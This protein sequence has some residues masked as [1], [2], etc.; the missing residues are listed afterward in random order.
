MVRGLIRWFAGLFGSESESG[1]S[2]E[3]E[4]DEGGF[5]PS[6]L[7]ASVLFAHGMNSTEA[8][9]QVASMEDE[10]A[11]AAQQEVVEDQKRVDA[12]QRGDDQPARR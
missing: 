6:R 1:E 2:D 7:D 3:A 8:A 10:G 12:Q 5:M 4:N 9:Q 11:L